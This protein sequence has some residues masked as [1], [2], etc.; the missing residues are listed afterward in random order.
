MQ[1][2][3]KQTDFLDRLRKHESH[4]PST[5]REDCFDMEIP[6]LSA[7]EITL[8]VRAVSS[9]GGDTYR[10]QANT[11]LG[12]KPHTLLT[13]VQTDKPIYKPGQTVRFR[14]LSLQPNLR[15]RMGRLES[16]W[17]ENPTGTRM[18]Q[19][20]NVETQKGEGAMDAACGKRC[21]DRVLQGTKCVTR[22]V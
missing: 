13:F 17:I 11:T 14:V 2:I 16:V 21:T 6:T 19:W 18:A 5:G 1:M 10:F 9:G 8:V 7:Q 15:P 4:C 20:L 22:S 12:V 3:V